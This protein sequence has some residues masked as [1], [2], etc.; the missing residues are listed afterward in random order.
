MWNNLWSSYQQLKIRNRFI[1]ILTNSV[2]GPM[3]EMA[4]G[5]NTNQFVKTKKFKEGLDKAVQYLLPQFTYQEWLVILAGDD[6]YQKVSDDPQ[7]NISVNLTNFLKAHYQEIY[8]TFNMKWYEE[9]QTKELSELYNLILAEDVCIHKK[10]GS[11]V[12]FNYQDGSRMCY[13]P[14]S[15][16]RLIVEHISVEE[17]SV[18]ITLVGPAKIDTPSFFQYLKNYLFH[19]YE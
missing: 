10:K 18:L 2:N 3:I 17:D 5:K 8:R 15:G 19:N 4:K 14:E 7:V 6:T 1:T 9:Y 13:S 12:L 16:E 11:A